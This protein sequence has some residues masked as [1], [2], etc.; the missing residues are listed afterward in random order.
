MSAQVVFGWVVIF[1]A[2]SSS[3]WS[4]ARWG[5]DGGFSRKRVA[6][7]VVAGAAINYLIVWSVWSAIAML[8]IMADIRLI[9]DQHIDWLFR[10]LLAPWGQLYDFF[11]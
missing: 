3:I 6:I 7:G 4:W 1:A 8:A 9:T 5:R 10:A 2:L 11:R